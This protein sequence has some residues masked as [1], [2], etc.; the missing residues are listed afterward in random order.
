MVRESEP[1]AVDSSA[2]NCGWSEFDATVVVDEPVPVVPVPE[3]GSV[4]S[5]SGPVA[6]SSD[7]SYGSLNVDSMSVEKD[8]TP[9]LLVILSLCEL[10]VGWRVSE[11]ASVWPLRVPYCGRVRRASRLNV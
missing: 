11:S 4:E 5:C 1:R 2:K 3:L 10:S 6:R 9:R 7:G 8:S